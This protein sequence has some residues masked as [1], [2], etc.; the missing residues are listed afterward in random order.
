MCY[1][2][3]VILSGVESYGCVVENS[4]IGP[5]ISF[6]KTK[7]NINVSRENYFLKSWALKSSNNLWDL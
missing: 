1:Q 3:F 7:K 5:D 2:E 6:K 4:I